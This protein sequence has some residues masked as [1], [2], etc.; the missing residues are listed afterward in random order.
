M[1][2]FWAVNGLVGV[3]TVA[4]LALRFRQRGP[5][6]PEPADSRNPW[7]AAPGWAQALLF[8]WP[9]LGAGVAVVLTM[10]GWRSGTGELPTHWGAG[11]ADGWGPREMALL[12]PAEMAVVCGLWSAAVTWRHRRG[13]H[14]A[15]DT[16]VVCGMFAWIAVGCLVTSLFSG[17]R[18]WVAVV[19]TLGALAGAVGVA[20]AVRVLGAHRVS[21]AGRVR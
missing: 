7:D 8:G 3:I 9:L 2:E 19:A 20:V 1:E 14:V 5:L 21:D 11:G 16:A 10:T 4:A 17:G 12:V 15:A 18:S 13:R 6:R